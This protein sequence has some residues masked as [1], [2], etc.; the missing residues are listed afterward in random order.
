[1]GPLTAA[2]PHPTPN[3]EA[4]D[5]IYEY[6]KRAGEGHAGQS[7]S[8]D[9]KVA[10]VFAA[11]SVVLGLAERLVLRPLGVNEG[12]VARGDLAR[13]RPLPELRRQRVLVSACDAIPQYG[14]PNA[15]T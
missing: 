8:V 7:H 13:A 14:I 1:M 5:L 11:A 12:G 2:P 10:Q 3:D 15:T 9:T 6:T 4:L